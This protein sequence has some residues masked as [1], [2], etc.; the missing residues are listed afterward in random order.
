MDLNLLVS[1]DANYLPHTVVGLTSACE[2]N[3]AHRISIYYLHPDIGEDDMRVVR[4]HFTAYAASVHFIRVDDA[5][6]KKFRTVAHITTPTFYLTLAAD[7][8]PADV[9]RVLYLDCDLVVRA[10]LDGLY[11]MDLGPCT[12]AAVR[13]AHLND[14]PWR[15]RLN[16]ITGAG[17]REYFNAGVMLIDL[18]RYRST[19]AGPALLALLDRHHGEFEYADQD[20]LNVV[21][22][23][24]WKA[25]PLKWNV[26]SYWYTLDF[27]LKATELP[28]PMRAE[29][30]AAVTNPAIIHYSSLS[31]PWHFMNSHR[32]KQ[33]YWKYRELTPYSRPGPR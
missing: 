19:E 10:A 5:E 2:S 12:I 20:A 22:A 27:W 8:L 1:S 9:G 3:R 29:L 23:G 30:Q 33:E 28:G 21:F 15:A 4:E 6:L 14:A 25:L 31:K 26:Q 7:L 16:E 24:A 13:D 17:V 18:A 11:S 32:L